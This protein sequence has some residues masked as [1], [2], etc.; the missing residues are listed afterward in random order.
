MDNIIRKKIDNYYLIERQKKNR[1]IILDGF[2]YWLTMDP[3]NFCNLKCPLCPTGQERNCRPKKKL[4]EEAFKNII[5]ILGP[6]L[7]HMDFCNWGE[8]LL[9]EKIYD[10]VKYA[11]KYNIHIKLDTNINILSEIN[12]QQLIESGL[13]KIILSVDGA[14]QESYQKY[15]RGGDFNKVLN[16]IKLLVENKKKAGKDSPVIT[17]QFLVFKHNEHEIEKAKKI[18][19]VLG[20]DEITFTPPYAGSLEWLTDLEP[21]RSEHYVVNGDKVEF[22]KTES[23]RLCNWLWDGITINSDDSISACCSVEEAKDDFWEAF[24]EKDFSE[25]WNSEKFVEARKHV[26]NDKDIVIENS[27]NICLRC[28]HIGLSNHRDI[29]AL[30]KELEEK[31]RQ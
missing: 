19:Y 26:V 28:D 13:D 17:W 3:T 29:E 14:S 22:K 4:D 12:A 27:D 5:D 15:R 21:Y 1:D 25:I 2:P 30:V 20:V 23:D 16:N 31:E 7:I 8:P 10:M 24:P 18:A 6:Y 9:N 11:K